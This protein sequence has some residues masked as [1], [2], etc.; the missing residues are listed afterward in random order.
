MRHWNAVVGGFFPKRADSF[1]AVPQ[2]G[3]HPRL[4][5]R[6]RRAKGAGGQA[7]RAPA[8]R[9]PSP[10]AAEGAPPRGCGRGARAP[11]AE[12]HRPP[13]GR[14][15]P[16]APRRTAWPWTRRSTTGSASP[17]SSSPIA[18]PRATRRRGEPSSSRRGDCCTAPVLWPRGCTRSAASRTPWAPCGWGRIPKTAPVDPEGRFR[19]LENLYV[20]DASVFPTSAAVNPSLTIA[21]CALRLGARLASRASSGA[22]AD[23]GASRRDPCHVS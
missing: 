7:R 5:L 17:S 23:A 19:G 2:A 18:T 3:R 6:P 16:A 21:A 4:L 1:G 15:R 20:A 10:G 22:G 11:R 9:D 13:R 12:D 14:R 8:A